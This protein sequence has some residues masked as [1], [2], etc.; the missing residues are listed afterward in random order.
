MEFYD[1]PF[2]FDVTEAKARKKREESQDLEML[3]QNNEMDGLIKKSVGTTSM[4]ITLP[5][6][7]LGARIEESKRNN[8]A[9]RD[10]DLNILKV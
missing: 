8:S 5:K 9:I 2:G 3:A 10:I 6:R 7:E 1:D 4:T